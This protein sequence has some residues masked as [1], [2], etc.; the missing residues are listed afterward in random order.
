MT[1]ENNM[2]G[3][4]EP[5]MERQD[6]PNGA[7]ND[8]DWLDELGK[9]PTRIYDKDD[10]SQ[11]KDPSLLG[12]ERVGDEIP[13]WL[14]GDLE[15]EVPADEAVPD[16]LKDEMAAEEGKSPGKPDSDRELDIED[17]AV[18]SQPLD[19]S[20]E[21]IP[22]W[23]S[24]EVEDEQASHAATGDADELSWLDQ[25]AAGEGAAI[26]EPPTL[27]W[28][29]QEQEAGEEVDD[30]AEEDMT[31]L[32]DMSTLPAVTAEELAAK[33]GEAWPS[34]QAE[35]EQAIPEKTLDDE[36]PLLEDSPEAVPEDPDEAMAWLER[37][38]A[39]QG[40]PAEELPSFS[41]ESPPIGVVDAGEMP[42]DPDEAMAWLERMAG[43]QEE[44]H[45]E[46]VATFQE[47]ED[48]PGEE[49]L[50]RVDEAIEGAVAEADLMPPADEDLEFALSGLEGV[51]LP[52]DMDE[53]LSWLEDMLL[54][55]EPQPLEEGPPVIEDDLFEE[56]VIEISAETEVVDEDLTGEEGEIPVDISMEGMVEKQTEEDDDA[57]AWLEQLAARQGAS[58]EELT[59][60]DSELEEPEAPEWLRLEMDEALQDVADT[61]PEAA[62]ELVIEEVEA[63]SAMDIHEVEVP[64]L[65]EEPL[66]LD[67][68]LAGIF[69][70]EAVLEEPD[71]TEPV[72]DFEDIPEIEDWSESANS[73]GALDPSVVDE[74][75]Q[76]DLAWMDTLGEVDPDSWL[77]AEVEATSPDL[78]IPEISPDSGQAIEP[79]VLDQES[80][81]LE[82]EAFEEPVVDSMALLGDVDGVLDAQHLQAARG[83]IAA[84]NLDAALDK[85]G[86]LLRQ[87]EGLPYLIAELQTSISSYGE[88]PRLQRLL[89]DTYVQNGQLKKAIEVYRQ[90]LDNL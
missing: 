69:E 32:D 7:N 29:E 52:G 68:E 4:E 55:K 49:E 90:A 76:D 8:T 16:W 46:M 67:S 2:S 77:E 23:L 61:E 58:L 20:D 50:V 56:D 48:E 28:D 75:T 87:G 42:E 59:T 19:L 54:E 79:E 35:E 88:Q 72:F 71:S 84:G 15:Q 85:F 30:S 44:P 74:A 3:P 53:A 83:A 5:E 1:E 41:V 38:A 64:S 24:D 21:E 13:D 62:E 9:E 40:A 25:I 47:V 66:K 63:E 57:M 60:I 81:E 33:S 27:S 73:T 45:E 70:E 18:F 12:K 10:V 65:E 82:A 51:E 34:R 22:E 17:T 37:L 89:G 26:E 6:S 31:W 39:R 36:I 80:P 14:A 11:E 86:E 78:I 43:E